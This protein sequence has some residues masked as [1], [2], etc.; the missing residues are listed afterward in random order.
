MGACNALPQ[1]QGQGGVNLGL[2]QQQGGQAPVTSQCASNQGC[3]P[4]FQCAD[5]YINTDGAGLLDLRLQPRGTCTE[6]DYPDVP[7]ICC[8]IPGVPE[9]Q[10]IG[11]ILDTTGTM[12]PYATGGTCSTCGNSNIPGVC[13]APPPTPAPL[14]TCP[15]DKVCVG[16]GYCDAAGN[17]ITDG[18]GL[19]DIRSGI[20]QQCYVDQTP[21]V[22]FCCTP[23]LPPTPIILDVCP[24]DS[25]CMP[26]FLCQGQILDNAG[27]LTPY[28]SGGSWS[29][30]S[31]DGNPNT[32]GVCCLNPTP[33]AP[34]YPA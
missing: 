27:A 21:E 28:A 2:Q 7:A 31:L 14:T 20:F 25:S 29:Q 1:Y 9:P 24:L 15:G 6:P 19:I 16:S 33:P 18:S 22:G 23:P 30:C 26:E 12:V 10:G 5:G 17:V 4:Y 8:N 34:R 13:C 32:P 3:V 11:T